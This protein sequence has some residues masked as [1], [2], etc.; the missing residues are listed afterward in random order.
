MPRAQTMI[1]IVWARFFAMRPFGSLGG[2]HR[3]LFPPHEQLLVVVVEGAM[4][5]GGGHV[6]PLVVLP[7]PHCPCCHHRAVLSRCSTTRT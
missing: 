5:V 4:V 2:C 7:V 3:S 1:D 6:V